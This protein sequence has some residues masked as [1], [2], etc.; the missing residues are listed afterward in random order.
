MQWL[1][2][3]EG[4]P[5]K[6][7]EALQGRRMGVPGKLLSLPLSSS[8]PLPKAMPILCLLSVVVYVR[9]K[10]FW[11][12]M[13]GRGD[14]LGRGSAGARVVLVTLLQWQCVV[15][16]PK[17]RWSCY[18]WKRDDVLATSCHH[19]GMSHAGVFAKSIVV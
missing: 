13:S 4:K 11:F 9:G 5:S 15:P 7:K 14:Q 8:G 16:G 17:Q 18:P 19:P 2:E 6:R 3:V 12:S 1:Q 10:L